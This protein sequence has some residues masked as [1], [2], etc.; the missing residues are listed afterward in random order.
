MNKCKTCPY[1]LGKRD[2]EKALSYLTNNA[3]KETK[4]GADLLKSWPIKGR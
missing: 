4:G 3:R 1:H 2:L